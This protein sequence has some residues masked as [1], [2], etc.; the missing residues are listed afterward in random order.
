MKILF[1][2]PDG[3]AALY[4]VKGYI[5]AFKELGHEA[6]VWDGNMYSWEIFKP[7]LYIGCSGWPQQLPKKRKCKIVLHVNPYSNNKIISES[8]WPNINESQENINWVVK[9]NPDIL[10]G[11]GD[12]KLIGKH[13]NYWVEKKNIS[14]IGLPT[15][16]DSTIYK[17]ENIKP[18]YDISFVGGRWGYK[19]ISFTEWL[20]PIL[21]KY[22]NHT[23][24]GWGGWEN[25]KFNYQGQINTKDMVSLFNMTRICPAISEPHTHTYGIDIPERIFKTALCDCLTITDKIVN[26]D[27]TPMAKT[28]KEMVELVEYY[29]INEKK[30]K[31]LSREQKDYVLKNHTY[32][33]R[34]NKLLEC[35]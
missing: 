21:K 32:I 29:L 34:V 13:W 28:P 7:D 35:I 18:K 24:Y 11:Y 2:N 17:K 30:R 19:S 25:T 1:F 8:N 3:G 10:F 20:D 16:A 33:I 5:N 15:A 22:K 26:F 6:K 14:I 12:D 4:I 9:Q 27:F 31:D 23:I